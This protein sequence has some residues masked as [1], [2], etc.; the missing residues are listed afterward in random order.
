MTR[1]KTTKARNAQAAATD[2]PLTATTAAG[3]AYAGMR[4]REGRG[5]ASLPLLPTQGRSAM[6]VY[7]DR[8]VSLSE[9]ATMIEPSYNRIRAWSVREDF[10][11][12]VYGRQ[13][14]VWLSDFHQWTL[15]RFGP[16]GDMRGTDAGPAGG[17]I[18]P[19]R[20]AEEGGRA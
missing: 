6:P 19:P 20:G 3:A 10:P 13:V 14:R 11:S 4:Q 16:C 7:E 1:T 5:T 15:D 9:L 12:V 18:P 8:L 2:Y 17:E